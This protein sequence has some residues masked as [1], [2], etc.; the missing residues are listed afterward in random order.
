MITKSSQKTKT[1]KKAAKSS[2]KAKTP[3]KTKTTPAKRKSVTKQPTTTRISSNATPSSEIY[4][5]SDKGK[6]I[7]SVLCRWW[8]AI[9]WPEKEIL[10]LPI[11]ENCD[12]LQGFPGVYVHTRG[13]SVGKIVDRRHM[14]TC[15]SFKNF[16]RKSSEELVSLLQTAID[17]QIKELRKYEGEESTTEVALGTLKKWATK[18]NCSKADK[19]AE[20]VL[21]VAGMALP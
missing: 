7:Q 12:P 10:D 15:P 17:N 1:V 3:T 20:K 19:E 18:I 6:L 16:A 13:E 8:Y 14:E 4:S 9:E 21:R 2:V 11:P 5:K